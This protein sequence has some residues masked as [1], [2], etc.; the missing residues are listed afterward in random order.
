MREAI[1][2]EKNSLNKDTVHQEG[3]HIPT[4]NGRTIEPAN[5]TFLYTNDATYS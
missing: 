1:M 3:N 5:P 2:E 4:K